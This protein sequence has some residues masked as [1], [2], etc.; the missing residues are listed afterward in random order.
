MQLRR[1]WAEG[2]PIPHMPLDAN[3]DLNSCHLHQQLQVI[4]CCIARKHRWVVATESLDAVLKEAN[5]DIKNSVDILQGK[6]SPSNMLY[7]QI[8]SGDYVLRLGADL[9]SEGLTMLET[10]E[11]IY[12]PITQVQM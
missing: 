9:P 5:L 2:Q 8:N 6:H 10:G 1:L 4:N 7:A 11:P 3:P 12:S